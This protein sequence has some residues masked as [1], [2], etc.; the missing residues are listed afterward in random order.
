MS[1]CASVAAEQGWEGDLCPP[2]SLVR[3][4]VSRHDV[5]RYEASRIYIRDRES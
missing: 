2:S 3:G 4:G 5:M 1:E